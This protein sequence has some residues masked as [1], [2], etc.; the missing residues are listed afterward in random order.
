ML[1]PVFFRPAFS[2]PSQVW[3]GGTVSEAVGEGA[4]FSAGVGFGEERKRLNIK[5]QVVKAHS[6]KN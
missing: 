4:E 5:G 1:P 2:L 3:R 6:M